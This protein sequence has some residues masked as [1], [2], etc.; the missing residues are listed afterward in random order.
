[1]EVTGEITIFR[2]SNGIN[3]KQ[4][5]SQTLGSGNGATP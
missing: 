1:M 5:F 2:A 4:N 3:N